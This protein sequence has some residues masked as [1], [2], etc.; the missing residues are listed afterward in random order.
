MAGYGEVLAAN[1]RA[2]RAR[3]DVT[4][5][6]LAGRMRQL[7]ERWHYQTV[8]AVERGVRPLAA[9]EIPA[10]AMALGCGIEELMLPAP[11]VEQVM[12]GD[13]VIP[14]SRLSAVDGSVAWD[15]DGTISVVTGPTG[16][17]TPEQLGAIAQ[18]L[19][20]LESRTG[21]G[22]RPRKTGR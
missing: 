21:A 7:G 5:Q 22:R 4:Q 13:Q 18:A 16:R 10:L 2:Y 12:F 9:Q 14:A 1:V 20:D 15:A 11:N 8:G 6:Q 19:A 17:Y 3:A